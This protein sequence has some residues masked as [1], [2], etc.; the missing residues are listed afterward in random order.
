MFTSLQ[1]LGKRRWVIWPAM[2][3]F[4]YVWL[5]VLLV[6]RWFLGKKNAT[7]EDIK[8]LCSYPTMWN[9]STDLAM[10]NASLNQSSKSS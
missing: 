3:E 10:V 2:I 4:D 6:K 9:S 1:F 5:H 8:H 7:F